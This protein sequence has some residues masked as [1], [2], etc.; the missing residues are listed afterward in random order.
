M[1]WATRRPKGRIPVAAK[2][3]GTSD[4]PRGQI[5][6]G[7]APLIFVLHAHGAGRR[8]RHSGMDPA[9]S[10]DGGLLVRGEDAVRPDFDTNQIHGCDFP[11]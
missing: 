7:T 4:I 6:P 1:T 9:A 3:L 10:L 8:W 2:D 11:R 5:G